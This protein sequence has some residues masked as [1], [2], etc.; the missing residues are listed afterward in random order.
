MTSQI[1]SATGVV[2]LYLDVT[3]LE[4]LHAQG[5][6]LGLLIQGSTF[7]T[8]FY[9]SEQA[10]ADASFLA[11]TLHMSYINVSEPSASWLALLAAGIGILRHGRISRSRRAVKE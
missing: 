4:L 3:K 11:P 2:R 6:Y 8:D 7:A 9:A 1:I 10:A 5:G